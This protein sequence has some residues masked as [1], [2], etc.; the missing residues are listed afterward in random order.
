VATKDECAAALDRLAAKLGGMGET[1]RSKHLL[2]RTVSC[3][4]PDLNVTFFGTLKDARL[5]NV[6][7]YDNG[8]QAPK[9]QVRLS[10]PSD[11]LPKLV[12]GQL[13]FLSAWASGRI[14]VNGSFGDLLKLR[15]I[16]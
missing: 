2:E 4:V 8:A 1:D 9:A 16:F 10:I 11:D 7:S 5:L 6:T 12:D 14:K 15:K 13:N 3:Q